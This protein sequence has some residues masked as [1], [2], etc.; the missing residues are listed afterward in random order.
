[1]AGKEMVAVMMNV[2]SSKLRLGSGTQVNETFV[3]E[4]LESLVFDS[5]NTFFGIHCNI[6]LSSYLT[7][8]FTGLNTIFKQFA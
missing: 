1:M 4:N 3:K 5:C 8:K 6:L 2:V 7:Y